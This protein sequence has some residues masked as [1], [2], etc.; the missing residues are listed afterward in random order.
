MTITE[1]TEKYILNFIEVP[2]SPNLYIYRL[3][4]INRTNNHLNS[5]YTKEWCY[6]KKQLAEDIENPHK[7]GPFANENDLRESSKRFLVENLLWSMGIT[8]FYPLDK[9]KSL[10]FLFS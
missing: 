5:E 4:L 9:S 1:F 10:D 8:G 3:N 2:N 7:I 6:S